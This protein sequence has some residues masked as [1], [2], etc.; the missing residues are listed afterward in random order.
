MSSSLKEFSKSL[1]SLDSNKL[2]IIKNVLDT[3]MDSLN[4][5]ENRGFNTLELKKLI[6]TKIMLIDQRILDLLKG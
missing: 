4:L 5:L 2:N 6:L 3:Y 1:M